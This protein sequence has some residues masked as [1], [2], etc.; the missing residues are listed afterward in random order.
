MEGLPINIT[1]LVILA[2]VVISG[3]FA[4]VRGFVHEFLAVVA[5]VGAALATVYGIEYVMPFARRMTTMRA[6]ADIG[7]GVT[8]FLIVLIGL[9]ILTRM[10]AKRV[11]NS[12][13]NTLDRS[14]GLLFG[15][16]RGAVLVCLAWLLLSWALPRKDLPD[17]VVD[18]RSLPLVDQGKNLLVALLPEDLRPGVAPEDDPITPGLEHSFE[19]LVR[20]PAKVTGPGDTSGYNEQQRKD[21]D[22]LIES[23]Q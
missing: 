4:F 20:P 11:Q 16:L 22:R 8:I 18:A 13:L 1:D 14:L 17:W 3:V 23:S 9:T 2:V 19:D 7:S 21:M 6:V 15:V 10:L 5:W 12:S